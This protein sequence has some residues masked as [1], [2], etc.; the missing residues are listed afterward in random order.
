M[1]GRSF[2]SGDKEELVR[3]LDSS[4]VTLKETNGRMEELNEEMRHCHA[5]ELSKRYKGLQDRGEKLLLE[6]DEV[7]LQLELVSESDHDLK[8]LKRF[9]RV[10]ADQQQ[11]FK[12]NLNET[13]IIFVRSDSLGSERLRR[14][15][16]VNSEAENEL[17]RK[18]LDE[19]EKDL[20]SIQKTS[21]AIDRL[22]HRVQIL[23]AEDDRMLDDITLRQGKHL[24]DIEE[25][26]MKDLLAAKAA[27]PGSRCLC[28]SLAVAFF[29]AAVL[30]LAAFLVRRGKK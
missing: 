22:C 18:L 6:I 11:R 2:R 8:L 23:V 7:F 30:L 14:M 4:L 17:E 28:W 9:E 3:F 10:L 26:L 5:A 19:R 24:M 27:S 21:E 13:A 15:G 25:R 1:R 20:R 29:I 16:T 12:A